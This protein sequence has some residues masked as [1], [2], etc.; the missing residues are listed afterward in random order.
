MAGVPDVATLA[1][2]EIHVWTADLREHGTMLASLSE[3][4]R[5]DERERAARF[6]REQ[7]RAMCIWS[8]GSRRAILSDY[9]GQD[10]RTLEL[11]VDRW[12]KPRL[13]C[14]DLCF[15]VSHTGTIALLAVTRGREVGVDVERIHRFREPTSLPD[16]MLSAAERDALSSVPVLDRADWLCACWCRKEA[17]LKAVGF[18]LHIPLEDVSVMAHLEATPALASNDP[19]LVA[20]RWTLRDLEAPPGHRAALAYEAGPGLVRSFTW[21]LAGA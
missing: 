21:P 4:L 11:A 16:T 12:G 10:P 1:P 6:V 17:V 5:D 3:L 15:N 9:L 2:G 7:D 13:G 20:N 19:R 14:V 8:H 18:G